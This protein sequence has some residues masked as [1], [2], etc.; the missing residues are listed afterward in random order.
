MRPWSIAVVLVPIAAVLVWMLGLTFV[1]RWRV[2][3]MPM[4]RY[5]RAF[6]KE[7]AERLAASDRRGNPSAEFR[8]M[9]RDSEEFR[10]LAEQYGR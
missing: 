4:S 10:T 6:T 2:V 3:W 8:V 5:Q 7:G 9:R 1:S